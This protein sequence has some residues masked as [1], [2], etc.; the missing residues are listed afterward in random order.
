MRLFVAFDVP[1][2]IKE[3]MAAIQQRIGN[4]LAE[5]R[6][7]NKE[8]MHLTLKFLG[9]VQ[10]NNLELIKKELRGVKFKSFQC[11]LSSIGVFPDE[12]H[13]R[14]VWVGLEPEDKIIELQ[15]QVDDKLKKLFTKEKDFKAHLTLGRV[16]YAE[17]REGFAN[18]LKKIN[19]EK[20]KF[21]VESF[22]LMKSTLEMEGPVYEAV[23]EFKAS[24]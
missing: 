18:K 14:I 19:V 9:E 7:V 13:I 8:Q 11:Y 4:D 22:K 12:G 1:P 24:V 17:N 15:Q 16:K 2:E 5:I 21:N 10:P 6:W 23:E 20:K 3:Y